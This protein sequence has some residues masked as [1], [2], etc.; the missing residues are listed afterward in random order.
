MC[1]AFPRIILQ[2]VPGRSAFIHHFPPWGDILLYRFSIPRGT[3]K[4]WPSSV[5]R[6]ESDCPGEKRNRCFQNSHLSS[7]FSHREQTADGRRP[8]DP[9]LPFPMTSRPST[10]GGSSTADSGP[11]TGT[12]S[13]VGPVQTPTPLTSSTG[14]TTPP[15]AVAPTSIQYLLNPA[16]DQ[17]LTPLQVDVSL[18]PSGSLSLWRWDLRQGHVH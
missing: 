16:A 8:A 9:A 12:P 13:S 14:A 6:T 1:R 2:L 4:V 15:R 3:L 7:H 11:A 18:S 10:T 5:S 17:A